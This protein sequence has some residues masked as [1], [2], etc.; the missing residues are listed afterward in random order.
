MLR[1]SLEHST[2]C[3]RAST[4]LLCVHNASGR[5]TVDV[6]GKARAAWLGGTD[7][8]GAAA[9][10]AREQARL[11]QTHAGRARQACHRSWLNEFENGRRSPTVRTLD[12]LL[13][14]CGLQVRVLLEPLMAALDARV[15][16]L[17]GPVPELTDEAWVTLATSLGGPAWCGQW[18]TGTARAAGAGDL[19][20]GR[21]A[22]TGPAPA[23]RGTGRAERSTVVVVL[24]DALRYWMRAVHAA[25]A[26]TS[27]RTRSRTG[28][29]PT[30]RGSSRRWRACG[31]ASAGFVRLRVVGA[32]AGDR[33]VRALVARTGP[34]GRRSTRWSGRT[35][36][37][38]RCWRD[39]GRQEDPHGSPGRKVRR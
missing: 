7:A 11:S 21:R 38:P 18:G 22:G 36:P 27:G 23:G 16:A 20:R 31:T 14:A 24:D 12:R 4:S 39:G 2:I 15:D 30:W 28:S 34:G 33:G 8:G 37:T 10:R 25:R 9:G 35:R 13:A 26:S 5:H 1:R 32:A 3:A 19:G 17:R 6:S 29:T